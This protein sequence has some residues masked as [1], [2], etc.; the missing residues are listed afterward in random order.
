MTRALTA[1]LLTALFACAVLAGAYAQAP[2]DLAE[3]DIENTDWNGLSSFVLLAESRGATVE[4]PG[5][6]DFGLLADT[7]V[8]V[9]VYPTGELPL[10]E[11]RAFVTRGGQIIVL[12]DF[13]SSSSLATE[14]GLS[15]IERGTTSEYFQD[16]PSLPRFR[17]LATT[18][19]RRA[20]PRWLR[21]TPAHCPGQGYP[22]SPTTTA[23]DWYTTWCSATAVLCSLPTQ[24]WR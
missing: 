9:V 1:T 12:D 7:D 6:V 22:C 20:H 5:D 16:N 10:A 15:R 4:Q 21:I 2:G 3:Y 14:F 18:R 23:P 19:C 24:A 8:L 11:L 13:G 17:R